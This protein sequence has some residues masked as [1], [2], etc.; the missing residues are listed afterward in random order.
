MA[1][2]VEQAAVRGLARR[3]HESAQQ[4]CEETLAARLGP[5]NQLP[6]E[7]RNALTDAARKAIDAAT[8]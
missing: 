1:S 3:L 7:T 2:E 5:F 6:E 8:S 4:W